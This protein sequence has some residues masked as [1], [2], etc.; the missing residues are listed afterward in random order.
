METQKVDI[1][2]IGSGPSGCISASIAAQSGL[3]VMVIEKEKF[4]RFVIGESLLPRCMVALTEAGLLDT[5][6]EQGFQQK[7]GA[8]F[9]QDDKV[10]EFNFADQFT[11]GW[12][13]TWQVP[14][15]DFDK[16]MADK[17]VERGIPV[18]FETTVTGVTFH[19]S[20]SVTTVV[21]KDGNSRQIE[22]KF[23]IDSS[24]YGRV[25]PRLFDLD[26]PSSLGSRKAFFTH[27]KDINRPTT[28]NNAQIIVVD[29][30]P[31]V[32]IW[33]IPFSNGNCS[34]GFV[35]DPAFFDQFDGA[36]D[37]EKLRNII[38]SDSNIRDRFR[39]VPFV[40]DNPRT[41][42][43]YSIATKKFY[44][45]GFALTG[46]A[47]EF[48]DP[49]F[50]SGVTFAVESGMVA[51]KLASRQIKGEPVDWEN[52]YKNYIKY[53]VDTFRTYVRAWYEGKLQDIFF[54]PQID[55]KI[56]KMICSVLAGYVWDKENYYVR[57]HARAIDTLSAIVRIERDKREKAVI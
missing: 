26:E 24:G 15:A 48:L 44:G 16:A 14:R 10:C 34:V 19:G 29:H 52:E 41:I 42:L 23:I 54:S 2:V 27:V 12:S 5:V 31:G 51:A 47:A 56:K 55:E 37:E 17:L 40:W 25:L 49:V 36:N 28:H 1:L 53:G 33:V 39:D 43:G 22:A 50:S 7:F 57:E 4:P 46:N 18:H 8:K 21:D 11:D 9:L 38:E 45:D 30:K 3:N 6:K 35:G 13:W 20:D 32:W